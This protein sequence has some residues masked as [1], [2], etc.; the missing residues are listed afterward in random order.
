MDI[1]TDI[2]TD[3]DTGKQILQSERSQL[4]ATCSWSTSISS[5]P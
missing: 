1:S 5:S 2:Y 4:N 3:T